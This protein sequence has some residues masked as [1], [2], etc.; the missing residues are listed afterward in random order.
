M[1]LAGKTAVVTGAGQR[2]GREIALELAGRGADIVIHYNHSK[3]PAVLLQA[4]IEQIGRQ[5]FLVQAEFGDAKKS[6]SQRIQ[7]FV[8]EVY[9]TAGRV[10][11]LVNNAAIFYP[12]PFGKITGKD[13]DN[14]L[15]VNLKAPF[16]LSQ[17]IGV[18]MLKQKSGKIINLADWT[19]LR[20]NARFLPYVIS[21]AGI[22]SMT[23]GLAKNLAPDIQV[24]AVMPGPILPPAGGMTAAA[25]KAAESKTLLK[26]FGTPKDIAGAVA[27]LAE[28][29]YMTG[30]LIPVEGGAL[31]S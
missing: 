29:D 20:P 1:K 4:Q 9:K 7:K 6:L 13:W 17:E 11:V 2:I 22:I 8:R 31:I 26:R 5:A 23:Q 12:T 25:K 18:R 24:N 21:K 15:T 14:F 27:F 30:A 16:F 28:S 3:K 10:D 19:G